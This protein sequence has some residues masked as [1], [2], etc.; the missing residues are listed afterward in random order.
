MISEESLVKKDGLTILI[1]EA[2]LST[3]IDFMA[4]RPYNKTTSVIKAA[5]F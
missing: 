2:N 5:V 1:K 3:E 4:T